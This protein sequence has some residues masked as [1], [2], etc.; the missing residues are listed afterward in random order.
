M[1]IRL[2]RLPRTLKK[3]YQVSEVAAI[4]FAGKPAYE[5]GLTGQG[6]RAGKKGAMIFDADTGRISA[7]REQGRDGSMS[8]AALDDWK[9]IDGVQFFH[10]V[11]VSGGPM[12]VQVRFSQIKINQVDQSAFAIPE[13]VQLLAGDDGSEKP[14]EE[15]KLEDFSPRMQEMINMMMKNLPWEDREELAE[16]RDELAEQATGVPGE[17]GKAMQYVLARIDEKLAN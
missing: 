14:A 8:T 2:L 9:T 13:E 16:A 7:F 6:Q 1:H 5:V 11:N 17:H 10:S 3:D 12:E 4:E 15:M